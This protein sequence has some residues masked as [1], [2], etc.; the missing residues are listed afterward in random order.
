MRGRGR[1]KANFFFA[2]WVLKNKLMGIKSDLSVG[3]VD[4]RPVFFVSENRVAN[5]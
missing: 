3:K 2:D 5:E 1:F 4:G